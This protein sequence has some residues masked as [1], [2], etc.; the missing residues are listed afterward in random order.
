MYVA[1]AGKPLACT[2]TGSLPRPAWYQQ[3]LEGRAFLPVFNGSATYREQYSDAVA[4]LITDQTRAGLDIVS[5]GEMRFDM[6][7]GGRSWF[8][9]VFDRLAGL[10]PGDPAQRSDVRAQQGLPD[11][12][13]GA[14]GDIMHEFAETKLPPVVTGAIGPGILQY[15]AVW[16]VAQ[17]MTGRPVK[18]GGCC[19]QMI[20][21]QIEN[22]FYRDRIETLMALP[23]YSGAKPGEC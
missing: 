22:H 4:A 11:G 8:G 9:Y 20:E 19:G 17:R 6:D 5:D 21:R 16:K 10:T 14:P 2:I 12:R 23:S 18:L 13:Q 1:S 7:I 15:D 3:N